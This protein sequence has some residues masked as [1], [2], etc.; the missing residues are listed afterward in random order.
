MKDHNERFR[1]GQ[2]LSKQ[3]MRVY[4]WVMAVVVLLSLSVVLP[5]VLRF[6]RNNSSATVQVIR[7]RYAA[8]QENVSGAIYTMVALKDLTV[9]LNRYSEQ[10]SQ[11]NASEIEI[12]LD[13]VQ[14][15][16]NDIAC[17]M[18]ERVNDQTVFTSFSYSDWDIH[19]LLEQY[20][21][22]TELRNKHSTYYTPFH[23]E[24]FKV[25]ESSGFTPIAVFSQR[26]RLGKEQYIISA[27]YTVQN[28][29]KT[30]DFAMRQGLGGYMVLNRQGEC[31]YATDRETA[32]EALGFFGGHVQ[33]QTSYVMGR[34][35]FAETIISNNNTIVGWA[36]ITTLM[37]T[38]L[39]LLAVLLV[40]CWSSHRF[41]SICLWDQRIKDCLLR[42]KPLQR[43]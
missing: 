19:G 26:Y 25:T 32:M 39:L 24:E 11:G 37:D 21:Q 40:Y 41:C 5:I 16:Y 31:L 42:C 13:S 15:A 7:D 38:F 34:Y 43:K 33:P 28:I 27:C 4:L 9:L 17:L 10:P 22:Y 35:Y 36:S 6:S 18:V 23:L 29:I 8:T 12:Y 14:S 2:K 1:I 30:A 3:L 20:L